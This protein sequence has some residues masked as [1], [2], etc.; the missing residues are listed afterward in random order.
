MIEP[1]STAVLSGVVGYLTKTLK[2][3]KTFTDFTKDFTSA[4]VNWIRPLFLKDDRDDQPK[5]ALEDLQKDPDSKPQQDLVAATIAA[6]VAKNPDARQ[7]LEEMY[8]EIQQKKA[9]G[10]QV[11]DTF[12]QT[13]THTGSGSV[14][15]RDIHYGSDYKGGNS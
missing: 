3:N 7:W 10:E 14:A 1:I 5:E 8:A 9:K 11:G 13:I 15:G 6:Y 2:E 12:I 4:T